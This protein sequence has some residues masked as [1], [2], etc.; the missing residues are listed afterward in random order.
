M[1]GLGGGVGAEKSL[2]NLVV[3]VD[4]GYHGGSTCGEGD[5]ALMG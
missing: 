5:T 3:L 1:D 2:G 4:G